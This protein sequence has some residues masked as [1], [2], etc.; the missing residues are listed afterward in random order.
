MTDHQ[1]GGKIVRLQDPAFCGVEASGSGP[2]HLGHFSSLLLFLICLH[3][4]GDCAFRFSSSSSSSTTWGFVSSHST[5]RES[6]HVYVV[7][8]KRQQDLALFPHPHDG[9]LSD[10]TRGKA[11]FVLAWSS[12]AGGFLY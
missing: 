1:I 12:G 11:L 4:K 10:Y 2:R 8:W 9:D 6:R 7:Q 3:K 5:G